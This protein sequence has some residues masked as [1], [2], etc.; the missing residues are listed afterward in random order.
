MTKELKIGE[1]AEATFEIEATLKT[2]VSVT[3]H[4]GEELTWKTVCDAVNEDL[5]MSNRHYLNARGL[6]TK[7]VILN[8]EMGRASNRP[9][10]PLFI[11]IDL[12]KIPYTEMYAMDGEDPEAFLDGEN[13]A[14]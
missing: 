10:D 14:D 7:A 1:P 13:D 11:G 5:K 12:K 2:T 4:H 9:L 3:V 6:M 8:V